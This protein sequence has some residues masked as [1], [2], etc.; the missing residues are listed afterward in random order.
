[1][2]LAKVLLASFVLPLAIV[3]AGGFIA[4]WMFSPTTPREDA[5]SVLWG[6]TGVI[7]SAA[8]LFVLH[9]VIF[10]IKPDKTPPDNTPPECGKE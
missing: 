4:R 9:D 1:M 10:G 5:L 3:G 8:S 6:I 2:K 7:S